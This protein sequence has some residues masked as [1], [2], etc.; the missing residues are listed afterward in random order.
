[1]FTCLV[2]I[3]FSHLAISPIPPIFI[4]HICPVTSF[5]YGCPLSLLYLL[6]FN[7]QFTFSPHVTE[8]DTSRVSKR[9][10]GNGFLIINLA[11]IEHAFKV[12]V[13]LKK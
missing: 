9:I 1:M 10:R 7:H 12:M 6:V 11:C 4:F 5:T 3:L 8:D 13:L 2:L